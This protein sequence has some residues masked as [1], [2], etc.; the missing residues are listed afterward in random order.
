MKELDL[1]LLALGFGILAFQASCSKVEVHGPSPAVPS[2][3]YSGGES[4]PAVGPRIAANKLGGRMRIIEHPDGRVEIVTN[5]EKS[6]EDG[7]GMVK[8]VVSWFKG[9]EILGDYFGAEKAKNAASAATEQARV[10]NEG[11]A[12]QQASELQFLQEQNRHAEAI[13]AP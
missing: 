9:A 6:F 10:A 5:D 3:Q 7:S 12:A 2:A 1:L 11:A 4:A 8:N 13:G